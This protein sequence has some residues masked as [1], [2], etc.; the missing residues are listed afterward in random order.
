MLENLIKGG[1]MM[2]PLLICSI[3]TLGACIDRGIAF[4]RN[5]RVDHRSLHS[6]IL[7]LLSEG[8]LD[9]AITLAASTPGPVAAVL[10][11]G[12]QS[13]RKLANRKQDANSLRTLVGK[14][15]DDFT[16]HAMSSVQKRFSILATVGNAAPLLGMAGTV[17]GMIN[18]FSAMVEHGMDAS[19]V[20]GGIS[21]ALIT[22]AAGLLIALAAVIPLYYFTSL[23]QDIELDIEDSAGNLVEYLALQANETEEAA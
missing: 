14:S 5:S 12:L 6:E 4:Y 2:I 10:L 3:A 7:S 18:S 13:Y 11:V 23:T 1:P 19:K 9:N 8:R 21:E 15:M 20:A 17:L 16:L 22:T